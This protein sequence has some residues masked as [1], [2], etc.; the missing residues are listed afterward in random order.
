MRCTTQCVEDSTCPQR[1]SVERQLEFPVGDNWKYRL[2]ERFWADFERR[3]GVVDRCVAAIWCFR[4]FW[5]CGSLLLLIFMKVTMIMNGRVK[6]LRRLLGLGLILA[7]VG[8]CEPW[9]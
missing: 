1:R 7:R 2:E 6:E 9:C 8:L 3:A 5:D 4:G